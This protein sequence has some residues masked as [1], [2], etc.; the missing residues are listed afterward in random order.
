MPARHSAV[1]RHVAS[2][3]GRDSS[4]RER[5][6]LAHAV[7]SFWTYE[8]WAAAILAPSILGSLAGTGRS[9]RGMPSAERAMTWAS[10]SSV[11]AVSGELFASSCSG[12]PSDGERADVAALVRDG[13]GILR[14]FGDDGGELGF[15]VG[16]APAQQHGPLGVDGVRPV[17]L[18]A[19]VEL[20]VGCVPRGRRCVLVGHGGT[21]SPRPAVRFAA[22]QQPHCLAVAR[23]APGRFLSAE[24]RRPISGGNTPSGL[25][26]RQ[27]RRA[28]RRRPASDPSGRSHTR[29]KAGWAFGP[30]QPP[31]SGLRSIRAGFYCNGVGVLA[32]YGVKLF[33][34]G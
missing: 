13:E 31:S 17:A 19:H 29:S 23:T 33:L 22:S 4:R 14:A 8:S 26:E 12:R 16:D 21:L 3:A 25:R 28:I 24:R 18:L 5:G 20:Q 11:F 27:G 6:A 7:R 1:M 32:L 10:C 34:P 2:K 9:A 15:G 30:A